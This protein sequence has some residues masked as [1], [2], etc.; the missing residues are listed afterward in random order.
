MAKIKHTKNALKAERDSLKRFRRY[1][2][3]L[4]LKKQQLQSELRNIEAQMDEKAAASRAIEADLSHWVKLFAQPVDFEALLR[5]KD[6]PMTEGNI[7][8]VA[9]PVIQDVVFERN[10]PDLYSSPLWVDD[11][12]DVLEKLVRLLIERSVLGEQYLRLSE[13]LRTTSQRV[14]LFEK[15]KIPEC[16]RNIRTIRIF[17][18]DMQT[19]EVARAKIAK[20]KAPGEEAA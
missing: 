2:P 14:N 16:E 4:L 15:V 10:M 18:G 8:G 13:E 9:I 6:V 19:A 5:V 20:S 7:A 12:F 3:T 11:G 17:L 1:L